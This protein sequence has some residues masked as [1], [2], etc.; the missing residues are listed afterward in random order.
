[1]GCAS[2]HALLRSIDGRRGLING[3]H[4]IG[5]QSSGRIKRSSRK[6][7][8]TEQPE[9][10]CAGPSRSQRRN[11]INGQARGLNCR[12]FRGV[13]PGTPIPGGRIASLKMLPDN[14]LV[15]R[16]GNATESGRWRAWRGRSAC[17]REARVVS[18]IA[19]TRPRSL[20]PNPFSVALSRDEGTLSGR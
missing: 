13:Q 9:E 6:T 1:M 17:T 11:R 8:P 14:F 18:A 10:T 19:A 4:R 5:L 15:L 2:R 7:G 16:W 12:G 20:P 3:A